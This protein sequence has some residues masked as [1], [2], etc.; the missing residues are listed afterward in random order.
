MYNLSDQEYYQRVVLPFLALRR[1]AVDRLPLPMIDMAYGKE[2]AL[3]PHLW[4]LLWPKWEPNPAE[5]LTVFLQGYDK[6][7]ADNLRKKIYYSAC[8]PELYRDK[9]RGKI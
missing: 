7:G 8:T 1:N 3:P 6:R 4:G 2:N 5:G 9:Y